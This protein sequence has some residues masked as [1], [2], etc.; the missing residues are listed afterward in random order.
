M[1]HNIAA[2][3]PIELV[4]EI[5]SFM[6]KF[7]HQLKFQPVL[8]DIEDSTMCVLQTLTLFMLQFG[9]NPID[10]NFR[11]LERWASRMHPPYDEFKRYEGASR[12]VIQFDVICS[13]K[14]L[15]ISHKR[16]KYKLEKKK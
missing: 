16:C 4:C 6:Y 7:Q 2:N 3:L 12:Y 1:N 15:R 5:A 14:Q 8:R 9:M 11:I 10:D 13:S